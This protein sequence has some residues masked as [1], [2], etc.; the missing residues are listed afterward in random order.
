MTGDSRLSNSAVVGIDS[1][2]QISVYNSGGPTDI[3]VSVEGYFTATGSSGSAPGGLVPL[4][5][6]RLFDS[7]TGAGGAPQ[8]PLTD[9]QNVTVAVAGVGGVSS[10]ASAAVVNIT[11]LNAAA[12]GH[13][14]AW[15]DGG[16]QPATA[17]TNYSATGTIS[18]EVT[19]P[20][21]ADGKIQLQLAGGFRRR[22]RGCPGMFLGKHH[23]RRA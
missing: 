18:T 11:A 15:P 17:A 23:G 16:T 3:V 2:G 20:I 10:N 5:G 4:P 21:G 7:R 19:V 22:G 8:I 12:D 9:G 1:T 6:A 14:F 13:V